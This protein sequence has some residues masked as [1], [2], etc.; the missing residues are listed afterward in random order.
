LV[1]ISDF[2]EAKEFEEEYDLKTF[3][4]TRNY[5]APEIKEKDQD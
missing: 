1:K 3:K 2:G 4:G 5:I